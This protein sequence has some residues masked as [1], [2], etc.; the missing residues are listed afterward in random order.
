MAFRRTPS[1]LASKRAGTS[2]TDPPLPND[3]ST[4]NTT[5][6]LF[7]PF[8][9]EQ[10]RGEPNFCE[11]LESQH[12][13]YT[14][15][16]TANWSTQGQDLVDASR[17][18]HAQSRNSFFA[19]Y[20][21]PF[22]D[23]EN[24]PEAG[25]NIDTLRVPPHIDPTTMFF[26]FQDAHASLKVAD[27]RRTTGN[28]SATAVRKKQTPF[29]P[30][31][32]Q[33]GGFVVLA[34]HVLRRLLGEMKHS[35]HCV[36]RPLGVSGFHLNYWIV[37]DLGG[38][39][40]LGIRR[41]KPGPTYIRRLTTHLNLDSWLDGFA[42]SYSIKH[43]EGGTRYGKPVIHQRSPSSYCDGK[44]GTILRESTAAASKLLG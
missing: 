36:E 11:A 10:I 16:A 21:Y 8:A 38:G 5:S 7:V 44:P 31:T 2:S 32:Y 6:T 43:A 27:L 15:P 33:A 13:T 29:V 34:G 26:C 23:E 4:T 24:K 28:L 39:K 42:E 14:F 25:T 18:M 1:T 17:P 20:Y 3:P 19:P 22:P 30:A 41:E 40:I 12:G 35:V 9:S 37:P